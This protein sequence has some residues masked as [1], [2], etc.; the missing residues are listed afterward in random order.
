M[1]EYGGKDRR[2]F[3]R[4]NSNFSVGI[5]PSKTRKGQALNLSQNG[6]LFTHNGPLEAGS[7]V[8]ITLRVPGLSGSMTARARVIR[9]D[10]TGIGQDHHV[11]VNFVNTD[12]ETEKAIKDL[13]ET[14]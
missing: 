6:L 1:A 11:A 2:Q 7:H 8:D 3:P 13:L 4:V 10:P 14:Y 5:A 12:D 9:S